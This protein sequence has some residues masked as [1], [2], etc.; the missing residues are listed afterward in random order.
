MIHS[1]THSA[2]SKTFT[3]RYVSILNKVVDSFFLVSFTGFHG[4]RLALTSSSVWLN[5]RNKQ[6]ASM[7]FQYIYIIY[8][9]ICVQAQTQGCQKVQCYKAGDQYELATVNILKSGG[10]S[11]TSEMM[12]VRMYSTRSGARSF[13]SHRGSPCGHFLIL[14]TGH[15]GRP[16]LTVP[17]PVMHVLGHALSSSATGAHEALGRLAPGRD[18]RDCRQGDD[19]AHGA[20]FVAI[21]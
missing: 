11:E 21:P 19:F 3:F 20:Q 15:S 14:G 13:R 5:H 7:R 4:F 1:V 12:F 2:I 18:A 9:Q 17:W 10:T 16:Y 8:S 6:T